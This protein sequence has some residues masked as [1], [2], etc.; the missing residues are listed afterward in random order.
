[1]CQGPQASRD[2]KKSFFALDVEE[3]LMSGEK[4]SIAINAG[5]LVGEFARSLERN[6]PQSGTSTFR[7]EGATKIGCISQ[8]PRNGRGWPTGEDRRVDLRLKKTES[9]STQAQ[10]RLI[11]KKLCPGKSHGRLKVKTNLH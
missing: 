4:A 11:L 5:R 1:M 2:P 8:H 3:K 6:K 7:V 9:L 10:I